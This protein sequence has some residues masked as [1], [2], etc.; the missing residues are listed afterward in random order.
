MIASHCVGFFHEIKKIHDFKQ[1][2]LNIKEKMED[3]DL[4]KRFEKFSEI[5]PSIIELNQNFDFSINLYDKIKK[6]LFVKKYL[7]K[8]KNKNYYILKN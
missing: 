1:I 6:I 8:K 4:I 5:Y 7:N 2:L 3:N